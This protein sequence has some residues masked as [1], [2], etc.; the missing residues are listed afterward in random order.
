MMKN[1]LLLMSL[2]FFT[3]C[4]T[5][6]PRKLTTEAEILEAWSGLYE[7][8]TDGTLEDMLNYYQDDVIRMG[9][10]GNTQIGKDLFREGWER[11]YEQYEV[12]ILNYSQP[13]ILMGHDQVVTYNTYD[14]IFIEKETADTTR[15]NG[16]WIG[17]W[18]LQ[19]DGSWKL[20]MTT[21]HIDDL[22]E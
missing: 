7:T 6:E 4:T 21:W 22:E 2:F 17:I 5:P 16:T 14:E 13:E 3:T 10:G 1:T 18:K 20:R 8:Y 11:T 12:E 19:D 9:K 15:A